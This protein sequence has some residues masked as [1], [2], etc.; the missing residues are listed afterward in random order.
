[1]KNPQETLSGLQNLS[2]TVIKSTLEGMAFAQKLLFPDHPDSV[3]VEA[4]MKDA[5]NS[6]KHFNAY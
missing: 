3:F 2:D 6:M 4:F 5:E 1:M